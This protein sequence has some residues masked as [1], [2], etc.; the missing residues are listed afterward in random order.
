MAQTRKS[1][2]HISYVTITYRSV[3]LGVVGVLALAALVTSVAFPN[4][5]SRWTRATGNLIEKILERVGLGVSPSGELSSGDA[6]PQQAHFTAI[7][8]SVRVRKA[9]TTQMIDAAYTV[10]LERGDVI[11]TG[12]E[13]IAKIVFADGTSYSVK[14]DS[15]IVVQENSVDTSQRTN[16][17]IQ[18]TTGTVDLQTPTI[19]PGSTSVVTVAGASASM[20]SDTSAEVHNNPRTDEHDI[21]VKRGTSTVSRDGQQEKLAEND[22]VVFKQDEPGMVKSR[23]IGPP[24]LVDPPNMQPVFMA[25]DA[26]EIFFSW[27]EVPNVK[28]YHLRISKNPYFSSVVLDEK[29]QSTQVKLKGFAEGSYYWV[30]R[31]IG[32][33]GRESVESERNRFQIVFRSGADQPGVTLE[34]DSLVQLGRVIEVHGRTDPGAHVFVNG[35]SV[36]LVAAD[37][38]FSHFTGKLE[39][40]ENV[41][42]VTAQ[43]AKGGVNTKTQKVVIQ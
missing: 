28:G 2:F 15:L 41:I 39:P 43:S 16:V 13:G 23:E 30:L 6:G 8:G 25:N 10:G 42:T 4:V 26:Q 14:P 20:G 12:A 40:G 22:K 32:N 19:K 38:T 7:D 24:T 11:Q 9:G 31:S 5:S 34:V 29:V 1:G 17:S 37:G 27:S 18:L 35:Q 36:P 3:L 33:S 21:M